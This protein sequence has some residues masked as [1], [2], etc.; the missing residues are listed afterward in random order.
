MIAAKYQVNV[1][2]TEN[3]YAISGCAVGYVRTSGRRLNCTVCP[4]GG[5]TSSSK[6]SGRSRRR[7]HPNCVQLTHIKKGGDC[8]TWAH[9]NNRS[10]K[11]CD[12]RSSR[13]EVPMGKEPL[14]EA[15]C[16]RT[17]ALVLVDAVRAADSRAYPHF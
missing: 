3:D 17:G 11:S 7:T 2:V 13:P 5:H 6:G 8:P 12:L 9:L 1:H 10:V 4:G 15:P 16:T 14:G